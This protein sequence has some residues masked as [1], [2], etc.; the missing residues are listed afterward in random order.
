MQHGYGNAAWI[1]PCNMDR[2]MKTQQEHNM[3]MD[4]D[5]GMDIDYYWTGM[6]SGQ[7]YFMRALEKTYQ[8]LAKVSGR[9]CQ[10]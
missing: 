9:A 7:L 5:R 4:V 6:D 8:E 3:G 2:D 10:S 1:W